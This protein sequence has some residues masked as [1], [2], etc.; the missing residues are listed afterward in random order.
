MQCSL[1]EHGIT[2]KTHWQHSVACTCTAK[3]MAVV[4]GSAL[5]MRRML[6]FCRALPLACTACPCTVQAPP[7]QCVI[8]KRTSAPL[9]MGLHS[10]APFGRL[11]QTACHVCVHVYV[12][13]LERKDLGRC[14]PLGTL[15]EYEKFNSCGFF[16]RTCRSIVCMLQG[17]RHSKWHM[18]VHIHDQHAKYFFFI[19]CNVWLASIL[20]AGIYACLCSY[21]KQ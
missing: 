2:H 1:L 5:T 11:Q 4:P 12:H 6:M 21:I 18:H 20:L 3:A 16:T 10:Y 15:S 19:Q 8:V 14:Q 13:I 9:G 17:T 7:H